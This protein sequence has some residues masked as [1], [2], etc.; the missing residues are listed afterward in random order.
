MLTSTEK[1]ALSKGLTHSLPPKSLN[2]CKFLAPFEMVF[3]RLSSLPS[4]RSINRVSSQLKETV[5]RSFE[6]Y[7]NKK[8]AHNLGKEE[9]TALEKLSRDSSIIICRPDKGNGVVVLNRHDYVQKVESL[10][11]DGS[12]F[13]KLTDS[14]L[15]LALKHEDKLNRVL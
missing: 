8:I 7:D 5:L 4:L 10:L 13:V 14:A 6:T 15:Q 11:Q 9:F 12:K 2:Y 1:K 3:R